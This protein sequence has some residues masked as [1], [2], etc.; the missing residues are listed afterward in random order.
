MKNSTLI[1][2]F[3]FFLFGCSSNPTPKA[4][5]FKKPASPIYPNVSLI[6]NDGDM[7]EY[8]DLR[9]PSTMRGLL[10]AFR[11]S[12]LF[13]R[14]DIANAY[15]PYVF[16]IKIKESLQDS[17]MQYGKLLFSSATLFMIPVSSA[18]TVTME[19][20]IRKKD[21][22]IKKYT[23]KLDTTETMFLLKDP[24]KAVANT[25]ELLASR[26]FSDLEK[27]NLLQKTTN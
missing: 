12:N 11:K 21:K 13:E 7:G 18:N 24:S 19:T 8:G 4:A 14:V 23:H 16:D 2:L 15:A 6:Y 5:N 22:I 10:E 17:K 27:D 1:L 9:T 20:R 25:M 3:M 26:L